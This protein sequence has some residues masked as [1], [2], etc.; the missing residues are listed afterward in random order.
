M[1]VLQIDAGEVR[2]RLSMP[3]CIEA[4]ARAMRAVSGGR[5][6]APLRRISP[7]GHGYFFLMPG[8]MTGGPV[9]GAKLLS[10]I[11]ANAARGLPAAQGFMALFDHDSGAPLALV[12]AASI[13]YLRTAATSALATRALAR[14]D[15]R[16]HGILGA[17]MLAAEHL[18]AISAVRAIEVTRVWARDPARAAAFAERAARETGLEVEA[19][20]PEEAAA[21]DIVTTVTG[22]DTPVL[23]GRWLS[24]GSHLNLVG[25]HQPDHR[26][27]DSDAVCSAKIYVDSLEGALNEAGDI[28]VPISEGRLD[29]E[30]IRGEIGQVLEGEVE[31]RQGQAEITLF[32][33]LGHVAQDIY[34]AEWVYREAL[35]SG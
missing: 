4:M 7:L 23:R 1:S 27:A 20:G 32:K 11:P 10:L 6:D 33:S 3:A 34:A 12:D 22:A 13:T 24:P 35:A 14:E 29:R 25:A 30:A 31:G 26:E 2:E 15:A 8:A 19:C 17:G 21:C 16:S 5:F 28:L 18:E 9:F